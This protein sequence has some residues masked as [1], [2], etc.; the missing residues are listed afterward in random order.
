[1][2][3]LLITLVFMTAIANAG[4]DLIN[5]G[6]G[7]AEK[8]MLYAY[9]KLDSYLKLCLSSDFCKINNSQRSILEK[10]NDGLPRERQ[11][12]SQI[13]FD[14][15]KANPG[16]F[17]I[18]GEVKVAKTGSQ[19]G[20]P[21][22]INTDLL[23][24]RNELGFF[25]PLSISECVAILVHEL[26][27]HYGAF[28]HTDLDL[29]GVRVALMLQNKTYSTPLLPWS[30]QISAVII[31]RDVETSYPDILLYVEDQAFDLSQQ[32][33]DAVFCPKAFIP[34]PFLPDIPLSNK[35]PLSTL[36]HNVHWSK[37]ATDGSTALLSI[38]ADLAHKCKDADNNS[39]RSQ[40]FLVKID[41]S[42]T[43][44]PNG[45]WTLDNNSIKIE[46]SKRSTLT[47]K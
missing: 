23:Y 21:V 14:S 19:I 40:D 38:R 41:F 2:K 4:G 10:I 27:H 20:S 46:Q 17:I 32:F 13:Q 5:N 31:N 29:T 36:A 42:V 30:E 12:L 34:I 8:N 15:E 9:Q 25:I 37:L 3:T 1:M 22:F 47:G 45:K 26:G 33:K 28:T 39:V 6:G 16:F 44:G 18:E 24:T 35:K 11:N 43:M 7:V